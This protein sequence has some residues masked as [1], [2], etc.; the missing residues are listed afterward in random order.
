MLVGE[1]TR[2][3]SR[4]ECSLFAKWACGAAGSALP[5][6]GRGRRFDPDQVHQILT[7]K[8]HKSSRRRAIGSNTSLVGA[9]F[10]SSLQPF[11]FFSTTR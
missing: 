6:H 1:N 11:N 5:W 8:I 3:A 4:R 9:S 7:P 2:V 10:F